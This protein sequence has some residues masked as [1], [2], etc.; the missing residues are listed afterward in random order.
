MSLGAI[1]ATAAVWADSSGGGGGSGTFIGLT[2]TPTGITTGQVYIGNSAGNALVATALPTGISVAQASKLAAI[3]ANATADQT[4]S[5]IK[6]LYESNSDT[7]AFT[8]DDEDKLDDITPRAS[9]AGS[10]LRAITFEIV[11]TTPDAEGEILAATG[12]DLSSL[13]HCT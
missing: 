4:A 8:D 6:S 11:S 13:V 3:E 5:Q 10:E 12:N 7:N 1:A 9:M 2:D